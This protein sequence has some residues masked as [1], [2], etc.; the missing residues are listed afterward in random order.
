[1]P[2]KRPHGHEQDPKDAE[3]RR[4]RD[5]LYFAR[6]TIVDHVRPD[7]KAILDVEF[8][9]E[10]L[11]ELA[12]WQRWAVAGVVA[13]AAAAPGLQ[14]T[15]YDGELRHL[16]PLCGRSPKGERGYTLAGLQRHLQPHAS[17]PLLWWKCRVFGAANALG[18]DHI[19]RLA[20]PN[21]P[22]IN[23]EVKPAKPWLGQPRP[24]PASVRGLAGV[25]GEGS[26]VH[27]PT[28]QDSLVPAT[29]HK[30]FDLEAARLRRAQ[31]RDADDHERAEPHE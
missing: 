7:L 3:I 23:W 12:A 13:M 31:R 18:R 22:K 26:D 10:S 14:C 6:C 24:G 21:S 2:R 4:L 30:V 25:G 19:A 15:G 27:R 16:C 28:D 1:M 11:A 8:A 5:A 17:Q 29:R 20:A 9:V